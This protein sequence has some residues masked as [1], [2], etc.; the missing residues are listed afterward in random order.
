M[1]GKHSELIAKGKTMARARAKRDRQLAEIADVI[2]AEWFRVLPEAPGGP[3]RDMDPAALTAAFNSILD[4]STTRHK[5]LAV[6][7]LDKVGE[8]LKIIV[9][10]PPEGVKSKGDLQDYLKK[11]GDFR[12]GMGAASLFGCGR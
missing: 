8:P 5:G 3:I 11:N 9:P 7:V 4:V 10:L 2:A 12:T 1:E 6:A